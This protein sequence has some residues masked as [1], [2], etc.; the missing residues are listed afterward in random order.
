M[1]KPLELVENQ[2]KKPLLFNRLQTNKHFAVPSYY[3]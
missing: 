1:N 2:Q 3:N